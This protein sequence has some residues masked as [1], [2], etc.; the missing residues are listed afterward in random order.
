MYYWTRILYLAYVCC[1]YGESKSPKLARSGSTPC[2]LSSSTQC[3]MAPARGD[4]NVLRYTC[5]GE[6]DCMP[7]N[8]QGELT[9]IYSWTSWVWEITVEV[10]D[11]RKITDHFTGICGI[12]LKLLKK[13]RRSQHVTGWDLK[14]L[15]FWPIMPKNLDTDAEAPDFTLTLQMPRVR[16]FDSQK[17]CISCWKREGKD[18]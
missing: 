5:R 3:W 12:H 13:N 8:E 2:R 7:S 15:G 14:T 6:E 16:S 1:Y 17:P 11:F 10:Q 9:A 4:E 18:F